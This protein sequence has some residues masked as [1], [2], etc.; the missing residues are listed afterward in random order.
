[1]HLYI[2]KGTQ[3]LFKQQDNLRKILSQPSQPDLPGVGTLEG[4]A[5]PP[6]DTT[7]CADSPS[8]GSSALLQGILLQQLMQTA[9]QPSPLKAMFVRE[10]MEVS[11]SLCLT[12][13]L[14][15]YGNLQRT[16]MLWQFLN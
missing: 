8:V 4:A 15:S 1:M 7:P 12:E 10:E 2:L 11:H 6:D 3:V 9:T 5:F 13:S 14:L 16:I